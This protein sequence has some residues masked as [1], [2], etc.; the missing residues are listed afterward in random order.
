MI[1]I[2]GWECNKRLHFQVCKRL[3]IL[4]KSRFFN[5]TNP[6]EKA[7]FSGVRALPLSCRSDKGFLL[8]SDTIF[9]DQAVGMKKAIRT[10]KIQKG[11]LLSIP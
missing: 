5:P 11:R 10:E 8:F 2:R 9:R 3:H 6:T 7:V 4:Q 1:L